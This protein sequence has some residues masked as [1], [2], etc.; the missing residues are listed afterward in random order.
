[1][2]A[3]AIS[4]LAR[5][6]VRE[7]AL[8]TP[9]LNDRFL[10]WQFRRREQ[11]FRGI[12][13]SFR[14][15]SQAA[16]SGSLSG[17]NH[18]EIALIN[19]GE[20]ETLNQADYPVLFWMAPLLPGA[21]RV[22]DLGGNIGV[23][24]YAYRRFLTFPEALRWT[25]CEVPATA[26]AGRRL[27]EERGESGLS[28]TDDRAAAD[29]CDIY[30]TAGALQYIEKPLAAIL[31]RLSHRPRHII[32]NRVPLWEGERFVT[33]QNNGA[34][35]VP[36]KV[37]N[38]ET[39]LLGLAGLGYDLIDHWR[40]ARTLEVLTSGEHRVE[41]YHGMYLRLDESAGR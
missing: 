19:E 13:S 17:Y 40:I 28:F 7:V 14:E 39:F 38:L 20:L 10:E 33:L 32:L 37:D 16:P 2:P 21:R 3:L 18:E 35:T 5:T 9:Y 27:A 11:S 12:Y 41:N 34:W 1:M 15:A 22:F 26:E 30:F 24:Y 29:D 6:L 36:Y 4:G 23:A 8:R 31:A 25:V